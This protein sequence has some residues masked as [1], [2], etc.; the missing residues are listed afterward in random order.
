[1]FHNLPDALELFIEGSGAD[2]KARPRL[3]D[4]ARG[5]TPL[6]G[7]FMENPGTGL[8]P[9]L[10]RRTFLPRRFY[11]EASDSEREEEIRRH[12]AEFLNDD[13]P[14]IDTALKEAKWTWEYG[15]TEDFT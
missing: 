9:K 13:L 1:M 8:N 3:F 6:F 12:W 2:E 10:Y 15:E 11:E 4:V 14:R 5:D 7:Q